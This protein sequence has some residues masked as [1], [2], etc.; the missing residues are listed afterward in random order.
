MEDQF[1]GVFI[2][3]K[4]LYLNR[5]VGVRGPR[6]MVTPL[7]E[8]PLD[9]DAKSLGEEVFAALDDYRETGQSIAAAEWELLNNELLDFFSEKSVA[10]FERK[11]KDVSIRRNIESGEFRILG[12]RD[13]EVEAA[14]MDPRQLGATIKGFLGLPG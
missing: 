10:A 11:K 5:E 2:F 14:N 13:E 4:T 3:K 1:C 6:R 8:L 9:I 12:P 7:K